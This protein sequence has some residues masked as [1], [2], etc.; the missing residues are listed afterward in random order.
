[1]LRLILTGKDKIVCGNYEYFRYI[2]MTLL[3]VKLFIN[4]LEKCPFSGVN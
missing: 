3:V 1:M 2:L 4:E